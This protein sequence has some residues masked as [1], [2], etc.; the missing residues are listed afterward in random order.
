MSREFFCH[1]CASS[2]G[3][4]LQALVYDIPPPTTGYVA[5]AIG[6]EKL[7]ANKQFFNVAEMAVSL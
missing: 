4:R 2:A 5:Y 1:P 7:S 3:L 6:L